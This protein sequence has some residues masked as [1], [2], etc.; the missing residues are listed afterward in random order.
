MQARI[1]MQD[2]ITNRIDII[3]QDKR[4]G[5][6]VTE[7]ITMFDWCKRITGDIVTISV[8]MFILMVGSGW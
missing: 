7:K 4:S 1:H 8:V 6:L 3:M 5:Y 2:Q